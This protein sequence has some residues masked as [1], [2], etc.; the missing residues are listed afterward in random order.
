MICCAQEGDAYPMNWNK[1]K[2]IALSQ[3]CVTVFAALLAALDI[4]AYRFSAWF[5]QVRLMRW[6]LRVL[7]MI[8]IYSGSIFAWICLYRLWRLIA[9][10]KRGAVFV[11]ENV[12]H[13]RAISWC[14]VWAAAICLA[15]AAYYLPLGF[16]AIAAGFMALIVRIVKN[17]FQ[18]AIAMKDELD[19]TI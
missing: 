5:V 11:G 7:L 15:S 17:A 10:I 3:I 1:D 12:T 18:Q 6:Q 9:N 16:V 13:M 8:S 4:G 2:S 19:L 14:C